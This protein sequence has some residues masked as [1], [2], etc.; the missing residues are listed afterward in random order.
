MSIV[1]W[2]VYGLYLIGLVASGVLVFRYGRYTDWRQTEIGKAFMLVKVCLVVMFAYLLVA[3]WLP[4]WVQVPLVILIVG[5]IDFGLIRQGKVIVKLQGGW[6]RRP[7][8]T[9]PG[10]RTARV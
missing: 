3:R 9:P 7:R 6:R 1:Y 5:G 10:D 4:F 8:K 2:I